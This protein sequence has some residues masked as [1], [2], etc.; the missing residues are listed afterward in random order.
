VRLNN[1]WI[2]LNGVDKICANC[3]MGLPEL[4]NLQ[5]MF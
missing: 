2:G 4:N 3:I 5:D 1:A